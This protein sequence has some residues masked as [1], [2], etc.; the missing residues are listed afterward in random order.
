MGPKLPAFGTLVSDP[1]FQTTSTLPFA[2]FDAVFANFLHLSPQYPAS[3]SL[4]PYALAAHQ[5]FDGLVTR[6]NAAHPGEIIHFYM[7]G[8]G[9]VSPPVATGAAAPASPLAVI[10]SSFSCQFTAVGNSVVT[11]PVLFAGLAPGTVRYYQVDVLV[12]KNVP[13]S[14]GDSLIV[15][16]AGQTSA[17]STAW[18]PVRIPLCPAAGLAASAESARRR[19]EPRRLPG[20]SSSF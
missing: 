17:S 9:P 10:T 1:R 2:V 16:N 7:T 8:L 18:I 15:C 4:E 5:E 11:A 3:V 6:A 20:S 19:C 13:V 12:P 14:Y